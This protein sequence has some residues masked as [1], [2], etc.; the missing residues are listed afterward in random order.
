MLSLRALRYVNVVAGKTAQQ[1]ADRAIPTDWHHPIGKRPSSRKPNS[2][3][4]RFHN[5]ITM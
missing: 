2:A 4:S 5:L 1:L 3:M